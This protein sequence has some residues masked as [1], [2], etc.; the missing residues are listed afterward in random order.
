MGLTSPATLSP[1][2][3]LPPPQPILPPPRS[4]LPSS[5]PSSHQ[6]KTRHLVDIH[7]QQR[8][9]HRREAQ[10]PH[11][12]ERRGEGDGAVHPAFYPASEPAFERCGARGEAGQQARDGGTGPWGPWGPWGAGGIALAS[13]G[14][15]VWC[16]KDG[17]SHPLLLCSCCCC[18]YCCC[19]RRRC[20]RCCCCCG[21]C[22]GC[23][24]CC[25]CYYLRFPHR[26]SRSAALHHGSGNTTAQQFTC[27]TLIQTFQPQ[28]SLLG[29]SEAAGL[30]CLAHARLSH[31]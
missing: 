28:C 15:E 17:R 11:A 29:A 14:A 19:C 12:S 25:C 31:G 20:C 16:G 22:C 30:A 18:C 6:L 26:I 23:C 9:N 21:C 24:C 27:R 4:I 10:R 5:I 13:V 7:R 3:S 1:S 2:L 8:S